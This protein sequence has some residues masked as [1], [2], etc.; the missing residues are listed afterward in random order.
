ML[1]LYAVSPVNVITAC[2]VIF[3]SPILHSESK[4]TTS[5][6]RWMSLRLHIPCVAFMPSW[7]SSAS[8][9]ASVQ[10]FM[11]AAAFGRSPCEE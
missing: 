3:I 6:L 9:A 7:Y 2:D 5:P 1:V 8:V 10:N 11:A 4:V